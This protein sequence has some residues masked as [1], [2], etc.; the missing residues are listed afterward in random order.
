MK[1]QSESSPTGEPFID[2]NWNLSRLPSGYRL[3]VCDRLK[4]TV[5]APTDHELIATIKETLSAL[6]RDMAESE[7]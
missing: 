4:L 6:A 3:G 2:A 7:P 1:E 5:Q